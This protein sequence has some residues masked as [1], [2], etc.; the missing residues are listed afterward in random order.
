MGGFKSAIDSLMGSNRCVRVLD[1]DMSRRELIKPYSGLDPWKTKVKSRSASRY[2]AYACDTFAL[3]VFARC[4]VAV[5][6]R[7][8]SQASVV[9]DCAH[10]LS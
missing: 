1:W 9:Q 2:D 3:L 10:G 5:R 7:S 6:L 4:M 8:L